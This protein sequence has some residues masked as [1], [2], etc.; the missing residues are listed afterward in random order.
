MQYYVLNPQVWIQAITR[1][2][3]AFDSFKF[4]PLA[5]TTSGAKQRFFSRP[6]VPSTYVGTASERSGEGK[7]MERRNDGCMADADFCMRAGEQWLFERASERANVHPGWLLSHCRPASHSIP[8]RRRSK[9]ASQLHL[10]RRTTYV[11][12]PPH[13]GDCSPGKRPGEWFLFPS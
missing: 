10:S 1:S 5:T 13:L 11:R 4:Y 12:T 9:L 3:T 8:K 7:S 6:T 2:R